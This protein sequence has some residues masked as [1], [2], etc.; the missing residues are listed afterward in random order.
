LPALLARARRSRKELLEGASDADAIGIQAVPGRGIPWDGLGLAVLAMT[1]A[2]GTIRARPS[3]GAAIAL[4]AH[5]KMEIAAK[6][7]INGQKRVKAVENPE[8]R[9][10]V[11]PTNALGEASLWR[12]A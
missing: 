11:P 2:R 9:V 1:H 5:R 4:Q 7:G 12:P 6:N 3:R 10:M 8:R